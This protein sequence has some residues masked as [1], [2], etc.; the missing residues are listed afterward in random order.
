LKSRSFKLPDKELDEE[1]KALSPPSPGDQGKLVIAGGAN[2]FA[3]A[4]EDRTRGSNG[5]RIRVMNSRD[6]RALLISE[7]DRANQSAPALAL[8]RD[9]R[10]VVVWTD[11]GGSG[12]GDI[13]MRIE[14]PENPREDSCFAPPRD[15]GIGRP[16]Q[17]QPGQPGPTGSAD[18]NIAFEDGSFISI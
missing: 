11:T 8:F 16:V 18:R 7:N 4:W 12:A 9:E 1:E 10:A 3:A 15:V 17:P 14:S 13:K 5:V 6:M 2:V